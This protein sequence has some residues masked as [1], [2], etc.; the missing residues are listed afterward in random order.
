M[1]CDKRV[2]TRQLC[3]PSGLSRYYWLPYLRPSKS[4]NPCV[5]YMYYTRIQ[6]ILVSENESRGHT[7][8]HTSHTVLKQQQ[9]FF[10][11]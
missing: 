3:I 1:E 8:H 4:F 5:T 11:F 9:S 2:G 7:E 6:K 10:T